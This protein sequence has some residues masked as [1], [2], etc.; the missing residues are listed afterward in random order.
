MVLKKAFV[1]VAALVLFA[2][3]TL[4]LPVV[5]WAQQGPRSQWDGIYTAAQAQRGEAVFTK[6]CVSC[7]P[8]DLSAQ[9]MGMMPAPALTGRRF[10]G[11]WNKQTLDTMVRIIQRTMP[12]DEPGILS[13]QEASDI[14]AFVLRTNQYPAGNAELPA[15]LEALKAYVFLAEK[16]DAG[17]GSSVSLTR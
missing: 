7:H 10:S 3:S 15:Q 6:Q 17:E 8:A 5:S 12:R 11:R 9:Q 4:G 13:L 16:P 14:T 2:S 1:P